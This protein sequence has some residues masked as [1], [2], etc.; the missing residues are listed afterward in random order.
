LQT[1]ST[2]LLT[3]QKSV[4]VTG[5]FA[6]PIWKIILSRAS[7]TTR[8]YDR[9]RIRQMRETAED[10]NQIGEVLLDNS[11]QALIALNF[12]KFQGLLY[13]GYNTGVARSIWVANTAYAVGDIVTPTTVTGY[14]YRCTVAGT[15]HTTTEPT[16]GTALGVTQTDGVVSPVTWEMDGNTGDEY[17]PA[18][19]MKVES[20]EFLSGMGRLLCQL[21]L[22]GKPN[23]LAQDK[24]VSRYTQTSAD[25][26]TVKTLISAIAAKT[27]T[28]YTDYTAVTATYDSEDSIIDSFKP[29]DFF[30]VETNETRLE[31][32]KELL[33]YTGCKMRFEDDGQMHILD[34][35]TTGTTYA[36]EY[37]LA[38]AT[39]HTFFSKAIRERFINPNKE[40]VSS[41]TDHTPQYSGNATSATS[42][43][44]D[45]KIRTTQRRLASSAQGT[46]IAGALIEQT[47]L[48]SERGSITVPMNVGQEVWDYVLVTD[49]RQGDT[50]AGNVQH[51]QR[52]VKVPEGNERVT[53]EMTIR[54]GRVSELSL[55]SAY[56]MGGLGADT[57]DRYAI[58]VANIG[59]L[60]DRLLAIA[61]A[62]DD[63][64]IAHNGL[65]ARFNE[66]TQFSAVI[67]RLHVYEQ[68]IIP[69]E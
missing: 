17:S 42:Y 64:R 4:G 21:Y 44:L 59:E 67:P 10:D 68:L 13:W 33:S 38:V 18:P 58:L 40:I 24:G 20:Q 46:V 37:R 1:L 56:A 48:A 51:Y 7:Q 3:A 65:V 52:R 41:H 29:A 15:S 36:Y 28:P 69:V 32:I 61:V 5:A 43:A 60:A 25:T 35:V 8:G 30:S 66:L 11:D 62:Y 26:N 39:Y 22:I 57:A 23:Q 54:F 12:E 9:T 55:L 2:S 50:R 6:D 63:L 27:L 47:E 19:V 34:P 16:W 45:P 31:K 53:W 14:Q 49:S